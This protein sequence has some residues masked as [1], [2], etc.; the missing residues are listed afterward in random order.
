M[1]ENLSSNGAVV[2]GKTTQETLTAQAN[3]SSISYHSTSTLS[4]TGGSGAGAVH[5]TVTSGSS[6][7]SISGAELTGIAIGSCTV[8]ATKAGD[9]N[10]QATTSSPITVTV[11]KATQTTL[12]ANANPSSIPFNTTST[13][14]TTGGSGTGAVSYTVTSGSSYC[15]ISDVTLTGI[16]VGSCTVTATKAG[17]ADYQPTTSSPITVTVNA[18]APGAPTNVTANA[19]NASA[20]VSW[21]APANTGNSAITNYTITPYIGGT[22]QATTIVG[23]VLTANITGLTNSSTYTFTVKATNSV[24]TGT[25]SAHSD[26]IT[27]LGDGTYTIPAFPQT[28]IATA[29]VNQVTLTWTAPNNPQNGAV[30]GYSV[31]FG[32]TSTNTYATAAPNCQQITATSCTITG[33]TNGTPYT[34]TVSA[35]NASGTGPVAYS[36]SVTPSATPNANP[37]TIALSGLGGGNHRTITITNN[38]GNDIT[39]NS[40]TTPTPALPGAAT[41][42]TSSS[43]DCS[44]L[45]TLSANGGSCTITIDPGTTAT[46]TSNC[47]TGTLPATPSQITVNT[48]VGSVNADIVILGYGCVYQGGYLYSIDDTT[49]LTSSIGGKVVTRVDQAGSQPEYWSPNG[50]H[51]S[52]W[53]IDNTSTIAQPSPNTNT[54]GLGTAALQQGQLNCDAENDGACATNNIVVYYSGAALNSYAAGFCKQQIDE[55][56]TTPCAPGGACYIDWYLPSVCDFGPYGSSGHNTAPYPYMGSNYQAC[57]SP[58]SI[59]ANLASI[60]GFNQNTYWSSNE[61]SDTPDAGAWYQVLD[62]TLRNPPVVN[63]HY[64]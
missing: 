44:L 40:V 60:L 12:T 34:F 13:L 43:E 64:H 39:V 24:G 48:S 20:T 63:L 18:S 4:T 62:L 56:G 57:A 46:S 25:E 17:D 15:S 22:A 35:T 52:I 1:N 42:D 50:T 54:P 30:T 7:C 58:N 51:D 16:A 38:S 9:A 28:V 45:P 37:S 36:S 8:V 3:P 31:L 49:P 23:D 61:S 21:S 55:S 33:L 14:S 29:G 27:P 41:L 47:T 2:N 19:G 59:Q 53:G 26:P 5:Y 11:T 10:Y 32:E 6:Y